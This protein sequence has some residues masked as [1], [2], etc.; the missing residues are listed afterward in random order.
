MVDRDN[1]QCSVRSGCSGAAQALRVTLQPHRCAST[2][3]LASG[4]PCRCSLWGVSAVWAGCTGV[5]GH[6]GVSASSWPPAPA[7]RRRS[8]WQPAEAAEQP[9]SGQSICSANAPPASKRPTAV[10]APGAHP[11]GRHA[12]GQDLENSRSARPLPRLQAAACPRCLAVGRPCARTRWPA[13]SA[14]ARCLLT[15]REWTAAAG[16]AASRRSPA[17]AGRPSCGRPEHAAAPRRAGPWLPA[18]R[19]RGTSCRA[20]CQGCPAQQQ[21]LCLAAVKSGVLGATGRA[22][23]RCACWAEPALPGLQCGA[24][25]ARAWRC[26]GA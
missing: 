12:S 21:R 15:R 23:A 20:A 9:A 2:W 1:V 17:V 14:A 26:A 7:T 22:A 6:S 19:L 24:P 3:A 8:A 16:A 5:P 11:E 4:L 13:A 18:V 10:A 25:L